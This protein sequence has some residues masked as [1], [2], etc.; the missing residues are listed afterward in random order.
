[1]IFDLYDKPI[2]RVDAPF[3]A[4]SA[5]TT[6]TFSAS[7]I[8]NLLERLIANKW[9]HKQFSIDFNQAS[10]NAMLLAN[11]FKKSISILAQT[12]LT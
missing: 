7:I 8:L 10:H 6:D 4:L 11:S 5:I 2:S 3:N 1:M 12:L 9:K